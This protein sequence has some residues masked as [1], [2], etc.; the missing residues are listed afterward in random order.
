M[1]PCA[2]QQRGAVELLFYDE[3][4]T[5]ARD[6]MIAHLRRCA[7]C[8]NAFEEL[9]MI[10]EAL[11]ARPQVSAPPAGDWSGFMRRLDTAV[12]DL[13]MDAG[14]SRPEVKA[15][16][17]P[18]STSGLL[19]MAALLAIV[20]IGVV[21]VANER[22]SRMAQ[23]T[24]IGGGDMGGPTPVA[25]AGL[26][27]VGE[28]HFERSKLVVLGL[29]AKEASGTRVEDWAYER[30]LATSLLK[31][32]RLYRLAAEERGLTSLAGVMRD[33]ELVL[34][35]T[36]MAEQSDEHALGQ[37]QRLIQKRGLIEKMDTVATVGM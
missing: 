21:F 26:K 12:R 18:A 7:E 3:L 36:S 32:T 17:R 30:E 35:E 16:L 34:L 20:T 37:I 23:P 6:E 5:V 13:R 2:F 24:A 25:T 4:D 28:D 22:S 19:A 29:S 9:K 8:S 10:R 27:S 15:R 11:A 1:T 14:F 33:L 31:D